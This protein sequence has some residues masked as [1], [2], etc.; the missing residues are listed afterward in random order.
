[1][2]NQRF[3][4]YLGLVLDLHVLTLQWKELQKHLAYLVCHLEVCYSIGWVYLIDC[5]H[6]SSSFSL[7]TSPTHR[8][9]KKQYKT[10]QLTMIRSINSSWKMWQR[11][12][13]KSKFTVFVLPFIQKSINGFLFARQQI[14]Q[15]RRRVKIK[16][17][18]IYYI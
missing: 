9:L 12:S 3:E 2:K 14:S 7:N 16:Y 5:S 10:N 1:M 18:H 15:Q 8:W 11:K 6:S 13:Q 17:M 4:F